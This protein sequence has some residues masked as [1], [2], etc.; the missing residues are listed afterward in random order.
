MET[1]H[2]RLAVRIDIDKSSLSIFALINPAM[3][4][5]SQSRYASY[6]I[7]ANEPGVAGALQTPNAM[8]GIECG[9]PHRIW[10]MTKITSLSAL[11][12]VLAS[13]TALAADLPRRV[14]PPPSFNPIPV[15]TWTG[16][17]LGGNAG[18]AFTTRES[19]NRNAAFLIDDRDIGTVGGTFGF[20]NRGQNGFSGGLQIGANYQF[21]PGSGFVVG[22]EASWTWTDL[23][24]GR[25]FVSGLNDVSTYR[26]SLDWLGTVTGRVGYAFDRFLVYGTGGFAYGNVFYDAQFRSNNAAAGFP[27]AYAGR[28][29]DLETGY[30]YGG[31]IEW[32]IPTDSFLNY[33]SVGRY[34]GLKADVTLKAEYLRY[35]LGSRNVLVSSINP[36]TGAQFVPTANGSYTSRFNTEGQL[37]RAGFNYKF[38]SY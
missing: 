3:H 8:A 24:R 23:T 1:L 6:Q 36:A 35:D 18:Y 14:A 29:D 32:A 9:P 34:L 20:N 15:F 37:I 19:R 31:G 21:T 5:A 11:L 38:G 12:A 22:V 16:F 10:A 25:S 7:S 28:Y 4:C 2:T 33:F 13:G 17:Y 30:V 26:Q 27:L